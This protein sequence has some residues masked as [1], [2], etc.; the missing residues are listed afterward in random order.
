MTVRQ[1]ETSHC[2]IAIKQSS[3]SGM[4]ILFIHGNSSCKEVFRNQLNGSIGSTFHC[5]AMD[6][7]GHGKSEDAKNPEQ[8]YTMSGYADVALQVMTALN[9]DSFVIV[10]WSLGG[11]I[12]IEMLSRS[13]EI[14]ALLISGTPPV[15]KDPASMAQAFLPS[16]HMGFTGKEVLTPEEAESYAHATCGSKARYENFLGDA[17][18]RTDGRA[19][20]IMMEAAIRGEGAD[21]RQVVESDPR[22]LAIVNGA[23]EPMVN[24]DY[25]KALS[26]KNLWED[27]VHLI[28]NVGHA[29]F[30]EAPD[31]FDALLTRFLL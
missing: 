18:R 28:P 17:V 11:H 30:W 5:I 21:Q 19:R 8:T 25:V 4:P 14:D 22:P 26:Y 24:N 13:S 20:R 31:E 9:L 16:D 1:V 2:K 27:K 15:S 23:D 12:G 3:G 7:P 10:G 29:P 6:L